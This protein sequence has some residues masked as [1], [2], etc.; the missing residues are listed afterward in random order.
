MLLSIFC[1]IVLFP[2]RRL[3]ERLRLLFFFLPG[4]EILVQQLHDLLLAHVADH[5]DDRIVRAVPYRM[6][7]DDI[8]S[9]QFRQIGCHFIVR[10]AVGMITKDHFGKGLSR[11][12]VRFFLLP[13]DLGQGLLDLAVDLLLV[14]DRVQKNIGE[15][16]EASAQVLGEHP[17]AC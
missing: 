3:R 1:T 10:F 9:N 2:D 8:L 11:N 5:G 7:I 17:E 14:K 13:L 4:L 6:E 12:D 15:Q 16:V